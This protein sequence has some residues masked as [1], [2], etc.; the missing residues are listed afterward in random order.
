V[1]A[2]APMNALTAG[3]LPKGEAAPGKANLP[4]IGAWAD[5]EAGMPYTH[6]VKEATK[7]KIPNPPRAEGNF[8]CGPVENAIK[9]SGGFKLD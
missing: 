7:T 4:T 6:S 1:T 3:E 2:K 8:T 5:A 9:N